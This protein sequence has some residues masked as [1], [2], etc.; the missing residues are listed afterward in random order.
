MSYEKQTWQTGDI[1]TSAKLNHMEDGIA[2]AGSG[3]GGGGGALVVNADMNTGA[4]DKTAGEIMA[5]AKTG[6]VLL[7]LDFSEIS[8]TNV[9]YLSS[10]GI[11]RDGDHAGE[12][13]ISFF[14]PDSDILINAYAA[15]E[16]DYPVVEGE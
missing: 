12:I 13:L 16:A 11:M 10:A 8:F 15:T 9:T 14:Y 2:A 6:L 3:G 7:F 5:A 4:L 1:V